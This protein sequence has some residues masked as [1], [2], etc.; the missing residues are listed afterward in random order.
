M[1]LFGLLPKCLG[2][3]FNGVSHFACNSHIFLEVQS[4]VHYT[5]SNELIRR[6][7]TQYASINSLHMSE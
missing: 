2:K 1:K 7:N 3:I 5:F 4:S 6:F